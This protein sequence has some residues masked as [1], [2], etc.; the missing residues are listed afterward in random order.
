LQGFG[1]FRDKIGKVESNEA[2][3]DS[4]AT[5]QKVEKV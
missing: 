3:W 5:T 2:N 4:F 1:K